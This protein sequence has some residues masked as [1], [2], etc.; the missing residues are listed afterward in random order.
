ME[1]GGRRVRVRLIL[2]IGGFKEGGKSR[3]AQV[4]SRR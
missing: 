1:E 2:A 4:V 3:E